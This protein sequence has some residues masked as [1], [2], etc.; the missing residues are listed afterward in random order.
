MSLNSIDIRELLK[1]LIVDDVKERLM[2]VTELI[3]NNLKSEV[4]NEFKIQDKESINIKNEIKTKDEKIDLTTISVKQTPIDYSKL[5]KET[6]T[7]YK[8]DKT[9]ETKN[10]EQKGNKINFTNKDEFKEVVDFSVNY[11]ISSIE[12]RINNDKRDFVEI[13]DIMLEFGEALYKKYPGSFK[14]SFFAFNQTHYGPF[15]KRNDSEN[16]FYDRNF[17]LY[18]NFNIERPFIQVQKYFL[19]LG[20]KVLDISDPDYKTRDF[21]NKKYITNTS[22]KSN[23]IKIV[24]SK[25]H[26]H[27]NH[28]DIELWHGLNKIPNES[29]IKTNDTKIEK[30]E[31][32][33]KQKKNKSNKRP[34]SK[35]D[36]RIPTTEEAFDT[37]ISKLEVEKEEKEEEEDD[38][39]DDNLINDI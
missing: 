11:C 1:I 25:L 8:E 31:T 17:T 27:M 6:K 7:D 23:K 4:K 24:V 30:N 5:I 32:V 39:D 29:I 9:T 34:S 16:N 18:E 37:T 13:T 20:Y 35:E 33:K 38:D 22:I 14:N 12:K 26:Y 2:A 19:P 21:I 15:K 3:N 36:S 28:E 10:P